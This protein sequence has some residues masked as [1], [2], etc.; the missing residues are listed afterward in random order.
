MQISSIILAAVTVLFLP[1]NVIADKHTGTKWNIDEV[2]VSNEGDNLSFTYGN[3]DPS[4]DTSLMFA[5]I[6]DRECYASTETTSYGKAGIETEASELFPDLALTRSPDGTAMIFSFKTNTRE[7]ALN[8][9]LYDESTLTNTKETATTDS[10]M[11]YNKQLGKMEFCI[12]FSLFEFNA[13]KSLVTAKNFQESVISLNVQP[14]VQTVMTTE[15]KY[16]AEA[17]LCADQQEGPPFTQGTML[18]I[19]IVPDVFA[20]AAGI[21]IE[22]L[23]HFTWSRRDSGTSQQA[24]IR[25]NTVS[26]NGLTTLNNTNGDGTEY[27]LESVLFASFYASAG[28]VTGRGRA[29]LAYAAGASPPQEGGEDIKM[30]TTFS[31]EVKGLSNS[32]VDVEEEP[33]VSNDPVIDVPDL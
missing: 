30:H 21:M 7:I 12:R 10:G 9:A 2:A 33:E 14:Q 8:P 15:N 24:V 19:C 29:T 3:I 31:I 17:R 4:I 28:S 16:K 26:N 32:T 18:R 13:E 22:S 6:Y 5:G 1:V 23:D 11:T 25:A 27:R 20:S